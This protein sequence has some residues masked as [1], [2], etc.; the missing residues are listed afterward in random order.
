MIIWTNNDSTM[1]TVTSNDGG[2][3]FDSSIINAG[4]TFKLDT[5]TLEIGKHEYLCIVHPWMTASFDLTD[6]SGARLAEGA[7]ATDPN[8]IPPEEIPVE[9]A[10][11]EVPAETPV[12][13]TVETPE[14][15]V[16]APETAP[17]ETP[18]EEA[19]IAAP[20]ELVI[21]DMAVGTASNTNCGNECFIPNIAHVTVGGTVTW[22]NVDTAAHTAT[23]M[24]SKFDSSLLAAGAEYSHT[25]SEAGTFEYMCI[26]H[27][28]MKGTVIVG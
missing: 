17:E 18:V 28:W 9:E 16:E 23:E 14:A 3:T 10:P 1:H 22:K 21:V 6:S 2:A 4:E 12:E 15:P 20:A 11:I 24:E 19:P 13:P 27:P 26:V 7:T 5:S 8:S 25:F